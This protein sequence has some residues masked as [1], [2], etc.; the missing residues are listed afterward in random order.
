MR[1]WIVG[2]VVMLAAPLAAAQ[3]GAAVLQAKGCLGCLGC[4][5]NEGF[6]A[7][8][9]KLHVSAEKFDKSVHAQRQCVDCHT[10]ITEVPHKVGTP[11]EWR[12]TIPNVCGNCH[13]KQ[14]DVYATSVHGTEVL[15]NKNAYAAV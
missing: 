2:A 14:R 15:K 12:L 4:H 11:G 10:N 6:A 8:G 7:G 13:M 5:G 1:G 9:R 3:S